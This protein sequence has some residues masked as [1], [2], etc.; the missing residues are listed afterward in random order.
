MKKNSDD[1]AMEV[2]PI[3]FKRELYPL[4]NDTLTR[5]V[6]KMLSDVPKYIKITNYPNTTQEEKNSNK[7]SNLKITMLILNK[8]S[9]DI[10]RYSKDIFEEIV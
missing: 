7:Y 8:R 1:L 10:Q 3:E 2:K 4:F 5:F 6:G 9:E